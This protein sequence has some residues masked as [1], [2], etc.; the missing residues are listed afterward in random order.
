MADWLYD[1]WFEVAVL[2]LLA[3]IA[4]AIFVI[5]N[6]IMEGLAVS[7]NELCRINE[8]LEVEARNRRNPQ[9]PVTPLVL[10]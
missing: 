4:Y 7:H 2:V 3:D 6:R 8:R 9:Q 1:H 10:P 5:G